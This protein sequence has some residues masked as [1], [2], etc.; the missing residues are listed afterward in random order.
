MP[1]TLIRMLSV[2]ALLT[3]LAQ[4]QEYR[5]GTV[6]LVAPWSRPTPPNA[7]VAG[8]FV[9]IV[10]KG[11]ETERLVRISSPIAASVEIHE[12][13]VEDGIARMQPVDQLEIPPGAT[14]DLGPG[15]LH[16]MFVSPK[17][18]LREGDRFPGTLVFDKAGP[19]DV[20]FVVQRT[21]PRDTHEPHA[22][23]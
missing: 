8:G 18:R 10:N 16:L 17:V 3:G 4:A 2:V 7:A 13:A 12:S 19:I 6:T 20:M 1:P 21:R 22:V 9:R 14:I 15:G 5:V 11:R 23:D